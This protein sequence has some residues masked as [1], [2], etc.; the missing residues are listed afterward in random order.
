MGMPD[1]TAVMEQAQKMA[2]G[3]QPAMPLW[4]QQVFTSPQEIAKFL[5]GHKVRTFQVC[6]LLDGQLLLIY[7]KEA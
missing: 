4:D 2:K 1:L 6:P 3:L 7:G 5:N